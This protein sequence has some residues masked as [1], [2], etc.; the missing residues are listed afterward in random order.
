MSV[1]SCPI[2]LSSLPLCGR[3]TLSGSSYILAR[4]IHRSYS[5]VGLS[6]IADDLVVAVLV[7]ELCSRVF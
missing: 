5:T 3:L 2:L 6:M 1:F 4:Y 7:V